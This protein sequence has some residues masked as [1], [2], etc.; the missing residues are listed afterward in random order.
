MKKLIIKKIKKTDILFLDNNYLQFKTKKYSWQ[1]LNVN[2]INLFYIKYFLKNLITNFFS[3]SLK[4]I[5][6]KSV[7][8]SYSP[9]IIIDNHTNARSMYYKKFLKEIFC[10]TY[11]N[12]IMRLKERSVYKKLHKGVFCDFFITFSQQDTNFFSNFIRAKF[13]ALGSLKNN[14][15][16]LSKK[17][18]KKIQLLLISEYRANNEDLPHFRNYIKA[19][20]IIRSFCKKKKI[21]PYVA[22]SSLRTEK[23]GHIKIQD[24]ILFFKKTLGRFKWLNRDSYHLSHE[25]NLIVFHNSNLGYELL[26]RGFKTVMINSSSQ[27]SKKLMNP[28]YPL[29]S[30]FCLY[31]PRQKIYRNLNR[32]YFMSLKNW[33]KRIKQYNHINF[34]QGNKKFELLLD[35]LIKKNDKV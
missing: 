1:N 16:R 27:L 30:F 10:I 17:T 7:I 23:K 11:Q 8:E 15:V 2:I 9:K 25:S 28:Y 12:F 22:L 31:P 33:K 18:N 13:L 4:E 20:D 26:A 19:V 35:Q 32:I 5:Y 6:L 24:E 14:S 21:I 3:L 29:K 34:D